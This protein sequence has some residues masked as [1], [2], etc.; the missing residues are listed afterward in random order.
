MAASHHRDRHP[1]LVDSLCSFIGLMGFA[2]ATG[3]FFARFSQ[4]TANLLFSRNLRI[5][6]YKGGKSLQ[7]RIA[8]KRYS[9]LMDL[10]VLVVM[11]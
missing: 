9:L 11:T 10:Q 3:L 7:F 6:P 8:N 4:A 2:L 5:A 1:N